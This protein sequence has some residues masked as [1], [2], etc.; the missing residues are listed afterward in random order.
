MAYNTQPYSAH[1]DRRTVIFTKVILLLVV[2]IRP[3]GF[4]SNRLF[5][6][7]NYD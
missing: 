7:V 2:F 6:K 4:W 5:F 3:H 1:D